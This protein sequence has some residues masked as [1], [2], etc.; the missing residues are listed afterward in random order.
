[1]LRSDFPQPVALSSSVDDGRA[2]FGGPHPLPL[3]SNLGTISSIPAEGYEP[4]LPM[5]AAYG[6]DFDQED[7]GQRSRIDLPVLGGAALVSSATR[8]ARSAK[9]TGII[10]DVHAHHSAEGSNARRPYHRSGGGV[11]FIG[12]SVEEATED[13]ACGL[14]TSRSRAPAST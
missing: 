13:A 11:H 4:N 6:S 9:G 14:W 5:P 10:V 12:P 1:M 3:N 8:I 7:A 2:W